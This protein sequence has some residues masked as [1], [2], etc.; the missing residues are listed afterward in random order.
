[1]EDDKDHVFADGLVTFVGQVSGKQGHSN[2]THLLPSCSFS[3]RPPHCVQVIGMVCAESTALA[4]QAAGLVHVHYGP[5]LP[6]IFTIDDAIAA[7][8][9]W[10]KYS[11]TVQDGDV[12]TA[13]ARA[14]HTL[15]GERSVGA[16]EVGA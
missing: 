10:H 3:L 12:P 5:P 9:P 8:G 2:C 1:V 13:L 7:D 15:E 16:Q 4:E 11:H 6:S 14:A